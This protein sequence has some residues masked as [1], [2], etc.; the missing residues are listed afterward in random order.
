MRFG[1][2]TANAPNYKANF[3]ACN[4]PEFGCD[5]QHVKPGLAHTVYAFFHSKT[6][7]GL[8]RLP[9]R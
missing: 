2:P 1:A 6:S 9:E 8:A 4:W 3:V 5:T 7:G